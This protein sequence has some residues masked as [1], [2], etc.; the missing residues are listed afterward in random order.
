MPEWRLSVRN[1][2]LILAG[3]LFF[4]AYFW[5]FTHD[6]FGV[7]FAPDSIAN[8]AY[9]FRNFDVPHLLLAQVT[10]WRGIYRP[11]GGLFYLGLFNQYGLDPRPYHAVTLVL[12]FMVVC[13]AYN[14][15]RLLG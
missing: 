7:Y 2:I 8:I 13:L 3:C 14:V 5:Y 11:M 10:P 15:A 12:L 1:K 4:V 9:Y 6:V